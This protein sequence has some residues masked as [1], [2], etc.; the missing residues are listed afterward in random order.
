MPPPAGQRGSG[1]LGPTR[2][3]RV[4]IVGKVLIG[5]NVLLGAPGRLPLSIGAV[6][7][8]G[9]TTGG[10]GFCGDGVGGLIGTGV[11]DVERSIICLDVVGTVCGCVVDCVGVGLAVGGGLAVG[12]GLAVDV[13]VPVG[14]GG[15]FITNNHVSLI[16]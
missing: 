13:G 8:T 6:G 16:I 12:V 14:L 1:K 2:G 7:I 9:N 3:G 11:V 15:L 4:D 10:N 5:G